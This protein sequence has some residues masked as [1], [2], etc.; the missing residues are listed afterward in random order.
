M[1]PAR[2]LIGKSLLGL[3]DAFIE[4]PNDRVE[5][6]G[7]DGALADLEL[8]RDR[9]AGNEVSSGRQHLQLG[10]GQLH[11]NAMERPAARAACGR[12]YVALAA[13]SRRNRLFAD[14]THP[15]TKRAVPLV[16]ECVDFDG[17]GLIRPNV[18]DLV[19]IGRASCRE[20]VSV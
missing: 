16:W 5:Q 4:A 1:R 10:A 15:A 20:R 2:I 8:H 13:S 19:E 18:S 9:H 12:P 6:V 3:S 11:L 7:D 14:R 17:D